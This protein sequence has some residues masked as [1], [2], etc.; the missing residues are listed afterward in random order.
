[1]Q[2]NDDEVQIKIWNDKGELVVD[3]ICKCKTATSSEIN[4]MV[5]MIEGGYPAHIAAILAQQGEV[6]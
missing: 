1:M 4:A 6:K 3:E 2:I 5:E